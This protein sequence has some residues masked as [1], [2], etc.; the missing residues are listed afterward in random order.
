VLDGEADVEGDE[1]AGDAR[2]VGRR[3]LAGLGI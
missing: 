2:R 1:R 3:R